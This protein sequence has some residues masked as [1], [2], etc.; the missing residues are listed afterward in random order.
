MGF[1]EMHVGQSI[2][3]FGVE[4]QRILNA[5]PQIVQWPYLQKAQPIP[6]Q[7][8]KDCSMMFNL[9]NLGAILTEDHYYAL[10]YTQIPTKTFRNYGIP[11]SYTN[12]I[13]LSREFNECSHGC[14]VVNPVFEHS[15]PS[16]ASIE[17]CGSVYNG[18]ILMVYL[19][20]EEIYVSGTVYEPG[21]MLKNWKRKKFTGIK[22]AALEHEETHK[23]GKSA[24]D[25]PSRLES[26]FLRTDWGKKDGLYPDFTLTELIKETIRVGDH[27]WLI[28]EDNK[29]VVV[30]FERTLRHPHGIWTK[31]ELITPSH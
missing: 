8:E 31:R 30:K 22:A 14:L 11:E 18:S 16:L 23:E 25:D 27:K 7:V 12:C 10:A 4:A 21:C 20:A 19:R 2:H 9:Y 28:Y 3:N 5:K 17:G 29:Y 26:N 15:E 24:L 6:E 1:Q 13:Y